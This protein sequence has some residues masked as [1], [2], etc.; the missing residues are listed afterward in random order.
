MHL[1]STLATATAIALALTGAPIVV[2]AEPV[3][4]EPAPAG[5]TAAP[6][7]DPAD[8]VVTI[9]GVA[10]P[11]AELDRTMQPLL[12]RLGAAESVSAEQMALIEEAA[13]E[14]LIRSEL[15]YQLAAKQN[16]PDLDQQVDEQF[17]AIKSGSASEEEWNET[18]AS[19]GITPDGL[20]EQLKRGVLI[21][22][23]V[24]NELLAKIQITDAQLQAFYDEHP[25]AF[26]Q[27]E[28]MRASHILIGVE[29]GAAAED[30]DKAKRKAVEILEKVK[31]GEDFAELAKSESSCP[32]APQ[33]GDLGEFTR[34]QMV[35]PFETAAF[36][37]EPGAV[38]EVVETQFGYHII[39]ATEKSATEVVPFAEVKDRIEQEL[40]A[41]Q[42]Q[43]QAI[44]MVE[45]LR[46]TS[47]IELPAQNQ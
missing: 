16:I 40:Q 7:E 28:S 12:T 13:M 21:D 36:A 26:S 6:S 31:A 30:Q 14:N 18:L 17:A 2:A 38:S 42:V 37:L 4:Q 10:I 24:E 23:F 3:A 32:S 47:V 27:P 15:L 5:V 45:E 20:R 19:K 29:E 11:R 33:G 35:A 46:K 44:A 39:K 22:A 25:E 9:N 41:Q 43:E 34:G 8:I 1:F